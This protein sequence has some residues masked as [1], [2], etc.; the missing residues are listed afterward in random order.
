MIMT[1]FLSLL[2]LCLSLLV[3]S[4]AHASDTE[5]LDPAKAFRLSAQVLDNKDLTLNFTIEPNYYMYR[6]Q[7]KVA[8]AGDDEDGTQTKDLLGPTVLPQGEVLYDPT[9]DKDMEV[10]RIQAT[11]KNPILKEGAPFTVEIT[12]QGCADAGLCY[13]PMYFYAPLTPTSTG[14]EIALPKG[15]DGSVRIEPAEEQLFLDEESTDTASATSGSSDAN[16]NAGAMDLFNAGDTEIASWLNQAGLWSMLAI[17]FALGLAL[18]FTPCVLPM[19][20]ILLSIIVGTKPQDGEKASPYRGLRLTL[21][22]VLGT[23]IVYTILGIVAA[24]IGAA[25]ANWIQNPWVLSI[26]ALFLV[27]FGIAMFGSFTFQMPSSVQTRLNNFMAKLPAG[28]M[29]GSLIMG[30]VS[31]LICGPCV[32][33]PLAGVLLFISQT[34]DVVSG[35]LILFVLAWGQGASLLLLGSSSGALLPKSGQWMNTV[36]YVCGLL[37]FAAALWMVAPL[38]PA[39]LP[40]LLWALLAFAFAYVVGSFKGYRPMPGLF[41]LLVKLLGLVAFAWGILL[42]VGLA[43]G[44]RSVI[45]P[46]TVQS[47]SA[48]AVQFQRIKTVAELDAAL[49]QTTK[50]VLL[51]FYADWCISCREMETF[52]FSEANVKAK[53]DQMLLL[54]VDV[55]KNN[56]DDR[57]LLKRFNLFGPPGIIFFNKAGQELP[58]VRVIGFQNAEKFGANLDKVLNLSQ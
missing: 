11:L 31:A 37:L 7:F 17:A 28:Q 9:F 14:Y 21:M 15:D 12:A 8:V 53:M 1:R 58:N 50:P 30:M 33:A 34:G 45:S 3:S 38:L 56:R 18:S 39:W 36:K 35:G 24:S 52:T 26:F 41:A 32:A 6:E 47:Y 40:M 42:L 43:M 13:P 25:L 48:E 4:W 19:L 20:P 22:Y 54:Q 46:W 23:S 10:Y 5:F 2:M 44:S 55:T 27:A 29:G 16:S 49:S 51:D 57:A